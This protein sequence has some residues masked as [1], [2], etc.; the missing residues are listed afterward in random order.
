MRQEARLELKKTS[1]HY[2]QTDVEDHD[3]QYMIIFKFS[4]PKVDTKH[5]IRCST[6]HAD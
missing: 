1:I 4:P 3:K 5:Q 2:L 6:S